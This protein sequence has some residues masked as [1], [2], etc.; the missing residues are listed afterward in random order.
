M[1]KRMQ[2]EKRKTV[3]P[4]QMLVAF[5]S[6][7]FGI[8]DSFASPNFIGCPSRTMQCPVCRREGLGSKDW[9]E[10]QWRDRTVSKGGR[11]SC[12][13]GWERGPHDDDVEDFIR[14]QA[15]IRNLVLRRQDM[16]YQTFIRE[17]V[18]KVGADRKEWSYQGKLR[19]R[20]EKDYASRTWP[21]TFDP[22]NKVYAA[23]CWQA[24]P[25]IQELRGWA[26]RPNNCTLGDCIECLLA[27]D[28]AGWELQV[29]DVCSWDAADF[30]REM[31]YAYWRVLHVLWW[32]ETTERIAGL[33]GLSLADAHAI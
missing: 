9:T 32:N 31:S 20:D 3:R 14:R 21:T 6:R 1:R 30:F 10:A 19:I 25:L 11:N 26:N 2:S 4:K 8:V 24:V 12:R 27:F 33:V 16:R 18:M 22:S 13:D 29:G 5:C 15:I 7:R 28:D 17:F 23:V